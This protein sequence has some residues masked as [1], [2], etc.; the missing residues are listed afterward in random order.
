MP[1][2]PVACDGVGGRQRQ[3]RSSKERAKG[4][5]AESGALYFDDSDDAPM[6]APSAEAAPADKQS[7]PG[8]LSRVATMLGLGAA[9]SKSASA[10]EPIERESKREEAAP[11]GVDPAS[12]MAKQ[13]ASGLWSERDDRT[14]VR[15]TAL[16]LWSLAQQSVNS[17]HPMYGTPVK[18]A[19]EALL[20]RVKK[21]SATDGALASFALGVAWLIATGRRTRSDIEAVAATIPECGS[22]LGDERATRAWVEA[23]AAT[24]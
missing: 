6:A 18:K 21:L 5:E 13:L 8:V 22:K 14:A 4:G 11:R 10:P 23:A 19:V 7:R 17:T 2:S 15:E 9:S 16:A 3:W 20:E 12:V 1:Q 24:V